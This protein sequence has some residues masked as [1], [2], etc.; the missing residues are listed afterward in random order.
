M[1]VWNPRYGQP[2]SIGAVTLHSRVLQAPLSGVTDQIFRRL[3]RRYAPQSMLYT[4]MVSATEIHHLR[5]LPQVMAIAPGEAPISIQLFDGRPDFMAAA[6]QKAVAEGAQTID[7]NMGCPVNKITKKGGGSALLRDPDL[8]VSLVKATVAAV[9]VPVTVKTRLGWSEGEIQIVDFARR[10]ED[11]G[12]ALL[13]L[14]A[15]TRCQGYQGPA[16]WSWITQV[17]EALS[18]PVIANGDITSLDAALACLEET[19]ADGVMCSRGALGNPFLVGEIEHFFRTGE[20]R[21]AATPAERLTCAAEHLRLLWE[22]KGQRG[23]FQARKHLV[24]YCQSF[25]G[26]ARWRERLAQIESVAEGEDLLGQILTAL[27]ESEGC[28]ELA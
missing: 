17:K 4:E 23:L 28:C 8:A 19:G 18:I 7:I 16:Q 5:R 11:A 22:E 25:P 15:R 20:V 14:H 21:P 3:V 27:G 10:L 1:P 13:T 9:N 2:L 26:A 24:W 6:A 12:A